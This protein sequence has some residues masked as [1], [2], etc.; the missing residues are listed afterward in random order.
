MIFSTNDKNVKLNKYKTN[1]MESK[2]INS[3][4]QIIAKG[5]KYS[6]Y[7]LVSRVLE[8]FVPIA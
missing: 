3:S 4:E 7:G 5:Q 2:Q 1:E 6:D 8:Q